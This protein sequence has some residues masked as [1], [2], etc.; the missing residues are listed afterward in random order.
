[1]GNYCTINRESE[2]KI[3]ELNQ[4]IESLEQKNYRLQQKYTSLKNNSNKTIY[5]LKEELSLL[6]L[7]YDSL[8]LKYNTNINNI[9]K[10]L[11]QYHKLIIQKNKEIKILKQKD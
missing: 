7:D 11:I 9:Q 1:M 6:T 8:L 10:Q 4:V 5:D 3:I 2:L